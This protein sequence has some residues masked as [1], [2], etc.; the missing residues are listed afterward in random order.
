M[1]RIA[2]RQWLLICLYSFTAMFALFILVPS[3]ILW[4]LDEASVRHQV[5]HS[6]ASSG[7]AIK[8]EGPIS[9]RL[10]PSLGLDLRQLTVMERGSTTPFLTVDKVK[11][12]LA[13]LP[14]L[15]GRYEVRSITLT[16]FDATVTRQMN[17]LLSISDL[18]SERPQGQFSINLAQFSLRNGRLR[19]DDLVGKVQRQLEKIHLE[20][21]DLDAE[22]KLVVKAA[23][24]TTTLPL[25]FMLHSPLAI[26][27]ENIILTNVKSNLIFRT[28]SLGEAKLLTH[29]KI[30]INTKALNAHGENLTFTFSSE[31]PRSLVRLTAPILNFYPDSLLL[32]HG[33]VVAHIQEG[34]QRYSVKTSVN[35][36][37]LHQNHIAAEQINGNLE[38]QAAGKIRVKLTL[39]APLLIKNW[40]TLQLMPL[41]LTSQIVTPLLPRG[42]LA[43]TIR[44][45]IEG[46]LKSNQIRL[47]GLGE[48]DGSS[49]ALMVKQHGFIKP[50]HEALV[51]IGQLDL[52]RYLPETDGNPE[53]IFQNTHPIPLNWLEAFNLTGKVTIGTLSVGR[54]RMNDITASVRVTPK[55]LQI[56]QMSANIYSGQLQGDVLLVRD[57]TPTLEVKQTLK[58]MNIQPLLIDLFNFSRLEGK[59][60]GNINIKA[61]GKSFVDLRNTL[62][63]KVY[64]SLNDGALVGIDLV[65]ALKN[66]PAELTEWNRLAQPDQRT[67][68]SALSSHLTLEKGVG[69]NQDFKLVSQLMNVNGG[70]KI[71]LKQN[72][73]DYTMN[74]QANPDEFVRLRGISI[75]LKITGPL[76]SPVYA[77]D[78]N[79]LVK[80]KKTPL[81][82]QQTLKQ[83]LKK[84]I[85]TI[86]P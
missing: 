55:A 61:Y 26:E 62:S 80:G 52:N 17:G 3:V 64:I 81:E 54:F 68:F 72:I 49:I 28:N 6:L 1:K 12:R 36:L 59:G 60:S 31:K 58:G 70:G 20:A 53:A 40:Q 8:L 67:T 76:N 38:W 57:F 15:L 30:S 69:R 56:A 42:H 27:K 2:R 44:G 47:S 25:Q 73:I 84:Q 51:T 66:L 71:D 83:E 10:F 11:V 50:H 33:Q 23:L 5:A 9:I 18:F 34:Q 79:A 19:Y 74:V 85:N 86:L 82:K 35:Q 78:F 14:L 22:A 7:R 39:D 4:Q 63:G 32:P 37:K 65:S 21:Q 24:N 16:D 13:W 29:G 41:K 43:S 77:L 75:P 46:N 45:R 48:L